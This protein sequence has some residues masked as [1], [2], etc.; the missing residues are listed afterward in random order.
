MLSINDRQ[1]GLRHSM[2]A[3]ENEL[4]EL[5]KEM[6]VYLSA[7]IFTQFKSLSLFSGK[8]V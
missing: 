4:H 6:E 2:F 1:E 5:N 8:S 3:E 7:C